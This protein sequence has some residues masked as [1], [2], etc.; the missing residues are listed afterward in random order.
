LRECT[1]MFSV[2]ARSEA[3]AAI[4]L[5]LRQERLDCFASLATTGIVKPAGFSA[6]T[7]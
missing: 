4:Q 3:T 2:I 5:F 1:V 7:S 6:G